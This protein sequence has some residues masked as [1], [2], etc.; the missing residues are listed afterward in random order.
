MAACGVARRRSGP[1][2]GCR[3]KW[4]KSRSAKRSGSAPACGIDELEL[5]AARR[6]RARRRPSGSR[7]SSRCRRAAAACRW[8][9]PRPR[10]R[11]SCSASISGSSSCSS[12]SPP[13]HTTSGRA[14]RRPPGQRLGDRVGQL[15]GGRELAAARAV[16]AD[17]V[18]VAELA[19]RAWRG[20]PRGPSR[21]CSRRSGRRP[22]AARRSRP[23]PAACRRSP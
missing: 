21:G 1:S 16:G 12:G 18:G 22:P 14:G 5:V 17:E 11:A 4:S 9:R 2:I 15:A 20:P 13:V 7:R 8:S 3:K 10:S 23:R 19:D 6:A